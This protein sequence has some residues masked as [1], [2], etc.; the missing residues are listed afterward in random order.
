MTGTTHR[1]IPRLLL[2]LLF[3]AGCEFPYAPQP[4]ISS[5]KQRSTDTV[6]NFAAT[7]TLYPVN[8]G[9]QTC[10]PSVSRS[11][12]YPACM[13]WLG[14]SDL[15]VTVPDSLTAYAATPVRLHDRLTITDTANTVRW[16]LLRSEIA[17]SGELQC[18]EWS[19]HSD[20]L[21]CLVGKVTRPYSGY[22]VR[23]SDHASLLICNNTLEEFSTPHLWLPDS[24]VQGATVPQPVFD[25]N[26]I[27]VKEDV[28]RFFGT[29]RIRFVYTRSGGDGAV[30]V[31]DYSAGEQPLP[32]A[33][34]K[35]EGLEKWYCNS[36]LISP[37]GNWVAYH[38]YPN[39][40]QGAY[41]RSFI[42]RLTPDA[43]PVEIADEASD[44]HWWREPDDPE[45][46]YI[47]YTRTDG[48][49]Y[50]E[51]EY[52]D[53]AIAASGAI[54]ATMLQKLT[55]TWREVPAFIGTLQPD[56]SENPITLVQL[57]FKGGLSRDGR[58][59]CTAYKYAY[60]LELK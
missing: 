46:Y 57:P 23:L 2:T 36:P 8:R 52:T 59:L 51:N 30:H 60:L 37:D 7:G 19:T 47:V 29:R 16:Y 28:E 55:G 24:A 10:N 20:Y 6:T 27:A 56:P 33:L 9:M 25:E 22:A 45:Q 32:I 50:S 48:P 35:P 4:L 3:T 12:R 21:A 41:Y 54:G 42:Q 34:R 39:A 49:Y 53:P 18:P 5:Q 1:G 38:C 26:G 58:F 14:F 43:L 44:P 40:A 15:A 31:L 17:S 13:L 11:E